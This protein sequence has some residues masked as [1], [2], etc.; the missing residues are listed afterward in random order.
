MVVLGLLVHMHAATMLYWLTG[1]TATDP[2]RLECNC[3]IWQDNFPSVLFL[4][5]SCGVTRNHS[6]NPS[7]HIYIAMTQRRESTQWRGPISFVPIITEKTD[8][9][10]AHNALHGHLRT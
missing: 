6:T 4:L 7:Q 1:K 10:A 3:F 9:P 2:D 8:S 5:L